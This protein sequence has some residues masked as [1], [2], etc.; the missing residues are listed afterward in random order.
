[1]CTSVSGYFHGQ[2]S[3]QSIL[4]EIHP[5][6]SWEGPVLKLKL[7]YSGHPVR[8]AD[9]LKSPWCWERLK[10]G[11]E[12]DGR[13]WD[14]WMASLTWWTWVC[15]IPWIW[16]WTE[17]PGMLQSMGLQSRI[18]MS[19]WIVSN[20]DHLFMCFL[21]ICMSSLEKCLFRPSAHFFVCFLFLYWVVWVIC[22]F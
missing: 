17:R 18:W 21:L 8:K 4:R 16:L 13:R 14:G 15:I 2:I 1:M 11:E 9:S 5:E 20:V 7:Q 10:A 19:N 6:Y 12:G 3:N 22:I